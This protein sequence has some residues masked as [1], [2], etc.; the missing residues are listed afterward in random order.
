VIKTLCLIVILAGL[1]AQIEPSHAAAHTT[2][3]P[4]PDKVKA[5]KSVYLENQSTYSGVFNHLYEPLSEWGRWKVVGESAQADLRIILTRTSP[6]GEQR[7][8][9]PRWFLV[10][11]EPKNDAPLLYINVDA[12]IGTEKGLARGL[13]KKLRERI[14]KA[15]E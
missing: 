12:A 10:V 3:P 2:Y 13:V 14:E 7:H 4:L 15:A 8:F 11:T 9:N 6:T 5:A 1:L